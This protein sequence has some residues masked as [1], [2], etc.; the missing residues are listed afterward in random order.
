MPRIYQHQF[1]V[2]DNAID[3]NGHVNNI[4]YVKWM[5]DIAVMHSQAQGFGS[6]EYKELGVTWVV[7]SHKI[8]YSSPAFTGDQITALTWVATLGR[9]QSLRK[10][11]F[12]RAKDSKT[13]ATAETNWVFINTKSNRPCAI[14]ES[15]ASAFQLVPE[16]E[17]P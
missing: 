11:K 15:V 2:P 13:L 9:S 4:E 5:Q 10:Y 16:S 7:H 1:F 3:E 6:K 17:E 14:H 12:I 8:T